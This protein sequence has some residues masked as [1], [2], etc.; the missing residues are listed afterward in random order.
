MMPA[1]FGRRYGNRLPFARLA[2][3]AT[4]V[5]TMLSATNSQA[6]RFQM[7]SSFP[8]PVGDDAGPQA[9]V[10]ADVDKDGK[11]DLIAINRDNGAV[12]VLLGKGDGTFGTLTNID[13]D[14]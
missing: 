14:G 5:A 9:F 11:Q 2:A 4:I 8:V 10:L 12:S 1:Q 7:L 13:L 6:Q 3:A